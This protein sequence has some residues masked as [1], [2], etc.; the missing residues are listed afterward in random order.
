MD[1]KEI[2]P[3]VRIINCH[4][5]IFTGDYVP[6]FLA[7]TIA[8]PAYVLFPIT[9][10]IRI[11]RWWFKNK[12]SPYKWKHQ[13]WYKRLV[14]ILYRIK[15]GMTRYFILRIIKLVAGAIIV[16]SIFHEIYEWKL[17]D[18]LIQNNI[19]VKWL[20]S[21][22]AW[23]N[24]HGILIIT[25]S[26]W[27][28]ALLLII[29]LLFFPSG[30]NLLLFLLRQT[31]RFFKMLPGKATTEIIKRYINIVRYARYARQSDIFTKLTNQYPAGSGMIVLPM[32]M[33]FMGA[34]TPM[35]PYG[36]QMAELAKLKKNRQE[37]IYPFVFVD[38]RRS[39]VGEQMF[40]D[41]EVINGKVI[42]KD[43][44]IK[45]YIET[46]EFSGFK[47]YPALGYFPF[48]EALLPLWKYAAENGI[49]VMTHCIRGVIYYRGKKK[50]DWD[51]HPIFKQSMAKDNDNDDETENGKDTD[52]F[53][54]MLLPQ[55]KMVDLQ[56]VFTHP[57]NY[58]CL[59]DPELLAMLI[60]QSANEKLKELFGYNEQ[61]KLITQNLKDLKICFGHFGGDDEWT[62]FF[63]KDRDNYSSQLV[64]YP[65]RGINFLR[66]GQGDLKLGK[67]EQIW[68]SADWYSIICS[69]ML[70]YDHIYADIS[71]ILHSDAGILPLLKQTMKHERLK[72]RVLY[73][74]DFYVVRNHKS[75]K[76]M[77][78]NM[79][80]GLTKEEFEQMAGINPVKYLERKKSAVPGKE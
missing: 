31:S 2:S 29:L 22:Q 47:I 30:K 71:Y 34:G 65:D 53:Q 50:K 78:I 18:L 19:K 68:K 14:R 58:L 69:L 15:I 28:K 41:Y 52:D 48:D 35:K 43:C 13:T 66:N 11:F 6:P 12:Y 75:D 64:K 80:G 55:M 26:I 23:L 21:F 5:H 20:D 25:N 62:R 73:G 54:P 72:T 9:L 37:Q 27:L 61:T 38:P 3:A 57:L 40:F 45:D 42:L 63:E 44:F 8:G 74:S 17:R 46:K 49:P 67:P 33:E 76:N 1:T 60:G 39:H 36:E 79:M 77:L 59:L 4:T 51:H 16:I 70:Q 10:F 56:E 24:D 7:R 32:D